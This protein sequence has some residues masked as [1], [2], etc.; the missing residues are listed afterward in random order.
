[1]KTG[2]IHSARFSPGTDATPFHWPANGEAA[3]GAERQEPVELGVVAH[4]PRHQREAEGEHGDDPGPCA[5]Q[6]DHEREREQQPVGAREDREAEDRSRGGGERPSA[7]VAL[8]GDERGSPEDER[9]EQV[10]RQ[11]AAAEEDQR[12]GDGRQTGSDQRGP[13]VEQ[14][15]DEQ[16]EQRHQRGRRADALTIRAASTSC[17]KTL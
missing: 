12:G 7:A 14:P 1:M 3:L 2:A 15:R 17:P 16:V 9:D 5:A 6:A 11:Q 10:L 4:R 13:A 8:P